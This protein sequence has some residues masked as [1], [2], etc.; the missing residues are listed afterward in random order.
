[1]TEDEIQDA[2]SSKNVGWRRWLMPALLPI[3]LVIAVLTL[4]TTCVVRGTSFNSDELYLVELCDIILG[5]QESLV[6]WHFSAVTYLFPDICVLLVLCQSP[7]FG[8]A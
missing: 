3:L 1:M 7:K 8:L 2:T 4:G 6:G 5:G